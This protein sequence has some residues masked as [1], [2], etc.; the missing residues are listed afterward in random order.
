VEGGLLHIQLR[1]RVVVVAHGRRVLVVV[2][3]VH[4][5]CPL[6][7]PHGVHLPESQ[8]LGHFIR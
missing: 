6:V 8:L 1:P 4:R 3:A 5:P 2:G 7:V